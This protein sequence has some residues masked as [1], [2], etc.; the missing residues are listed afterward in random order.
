MKEYIQKV[1]LDNS[2]D[3]VTGSSLCKKFGVTRAAVWKVMEE[4]REESEAR[5]VGKY[6]LSLHDALP[7]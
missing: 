7:I 2:G 5:R 1:L 3:Y 6:T 4:L